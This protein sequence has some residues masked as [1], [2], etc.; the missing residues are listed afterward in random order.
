MAGDANSVNNKVIHE[1]ALIALVLDNSKEMQR[2]IQH[3]IQ[4]S[5]IGRQIAEQI[6]DTQKCVDDALPTGT[7]NLIAES[8]LQTDMNDVSSRRNL[9]SFSM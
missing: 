4:A 1:T 7:A 9:Q 2:L 3:H 8:S 5:K 6:I